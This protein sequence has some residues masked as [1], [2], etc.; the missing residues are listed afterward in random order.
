MLNV[1]FLLLLLNILHIFVYI[2]FVSSNDNI[3]VEFQKSH[4]QAESIDNFVKFC[5]ILLSQ[6][7]CSR[8]VNFT[9][10]LFCTIFFFKANTMFRMIFFQDALGFR[11]NFFSDFLQWFDCIYIFCIKIN[12]NQNPED[13]IRWATVRREKMVQR[14]INHKYP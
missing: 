1:W 12:Q 14:R 9:G 11:I 6:F 4:F 10:I 5:I 2:D 8:S 7:C 3:R 13:N